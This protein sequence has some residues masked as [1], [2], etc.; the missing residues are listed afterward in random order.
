MTEDI[1][2]IPCPCG[3]GHISQEDSNEAD[4]FI[5]Y[6]DEKIGLL[7]QITDN[8]KQKKKECDLSGCCVGSDCPLYDIE[9]MLKLR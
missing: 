1:E 6:I 4:E 3:K 5:K 2:L 8:A 9:K 7:N